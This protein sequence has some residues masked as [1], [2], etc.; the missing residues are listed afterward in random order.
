MLT[1]P[2]VGSEFILDTDASF[3]GIGA[4]LSQIQNGKERVIS[5]ASRKLNKHERSYC[6]TRKE[7]LAVYHFVGYF[8]QYLLGRKFR[9]RTDHKVLTWLMKCERPKTTQFCTWISELEIYDFEIE[10]RKGEDHLNA[11]FLSRLADCEQCEVK[12]ENPKKRRNIKVDSFQ[13]VNVIKFEEVPNQECRN[14]IL[15]EFHEGLGHLGITKMAEL[16]SR[17]YYWP[18]INKDISEYVNN[19]YSCAQRKSTSRKDRGSIPI[20]ATRPMEKIMI[21]ITGPIKECK[22]GYRYILGIVDVFSRFVMLIPMRNITSQAIMKVLEN[23]WMS[24]FGI[25]EIVISDA[26]Q[27]LN[28]ATIMNILE[29]LSCTYT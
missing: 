13:R 22:N 24:I 29:E 8:K 27:N 6:I 26:A 19:C 10:Y 15:K 20:T 11:D 16:L 9:I 25:P 1:F 3:D 12:H 17:N 5:Y 23:R 7:L 14:K 28:S 21:D 18:N 2:H 4:V